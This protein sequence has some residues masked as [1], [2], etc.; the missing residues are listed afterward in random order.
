MVVVGVCL[1]AVLIGRPGLRETWLVWMLNG[2]LAAFGHEFGPPEVQCQ[3]RARTL[4]TGWKKMDLHVP[5][6]AVAAI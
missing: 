5:R 3:S 2:V 1:L 6:C 4:R